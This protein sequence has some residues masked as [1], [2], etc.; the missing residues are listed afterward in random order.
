MLRVH[1]FIYLC[2]CILKL[3]TAGTINGF[4]IDTSNFNGNEAPQASV[5]ALLSSSGE[6]PGLNDSRVS[7]Q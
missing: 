1:L 5:E 3:G 7:S 2:R 6:D 4:D